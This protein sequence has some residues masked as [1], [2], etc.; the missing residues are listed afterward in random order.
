MSWLRKKLLRR[1]NGM[2]CPVAV[3]CGV[4]VWREGA[5]KRRSSDVWWK[6]MVI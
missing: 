4:E 5:A 1:R 6:R 3:G 2:G